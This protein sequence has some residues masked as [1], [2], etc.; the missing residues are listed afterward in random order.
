MFENNFMNSCLIKEKHHAG[1]M[2]A[3]WFSVVYIAII[4]HF[5]R[6]TQAREFKRLLK[7]NT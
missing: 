6:Q 7:F 1:F 3:S 5:I 4:L 2:W